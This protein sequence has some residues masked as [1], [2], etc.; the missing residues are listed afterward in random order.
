[1]VKNFSGQ[2]KIEDVQNEF[3][4]LVQRVNKMVTNYNSASLILL[5]VQP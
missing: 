2:V 5:L 4:K 1:M 3:D